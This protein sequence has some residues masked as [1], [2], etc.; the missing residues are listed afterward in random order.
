LLLHSLQ[1]LARQ[2]ILIIGGIRIANRAKRASEILIFAAADTRRRSKP[3][4]IKDFL[5][6]CTFI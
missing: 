2:T 3:S 6:P 1:S 4:A 5:N